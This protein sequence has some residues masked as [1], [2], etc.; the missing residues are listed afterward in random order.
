VVVFDN[1][2]PD[3]TPRAR[4]IEAAGCG[5]SRPAA[6][7]ADLLHSIKPASGK[8]KALLRGVVRVAAP[9][10]H[11]LARRIVDAITASDAAKLLPPLRT[12]V[13]SSSRELRYVVDHRASRDKL[14]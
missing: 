1:L 12:T 6:V 5:C 11:P 14:S 3:K 2:W 4:R 10:S 13:A 9:R 8:L 7:L